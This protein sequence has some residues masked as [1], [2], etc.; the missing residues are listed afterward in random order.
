M[1]RKYA[2]RAAKLTA[3][4]AMTPY[5]GRLTARDDFSKPTHRSLSARV[6]RTMEVERRKFIQ[7]VS[8]PSISLAANEDEALLFLT[9]GG[10]VIDRRTIKIWLEVQALTRNSTDGQSPLFPCYAGK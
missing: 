1:H 8:H 2:K 6:E 5:E 4:E 10:R 9:E 7:F 3:I